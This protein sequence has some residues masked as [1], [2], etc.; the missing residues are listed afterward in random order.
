MA[1]LLDISSKLVANSTN[2]FIQNVSPNK[3][4]MKWISD[5]IR[6]NTKRHWKKIAVIGACGVLIAGTYKLHSDLVA[7]REQQDLTPGPEVELLSKL[8]NVQSV[9]LDRIQDVMEV[10]THRVD[11]DKEIEDILKISEP[12]CDAFM[13]DQVNVVK[14]KDETTESLNARLTNAYRKKN[15]LSR[16]KVDQNDY[17]IALKSL[18]NRAKLAF[19]IPKDS[20]LHVQAVNLFLYKECRKLNI[21]TADAARLIPQAVALSI[22]PNDEQIAY[23]QVLKLPEIQRRYLA[24]NWRGGSPSLGVRMVNSIRSWVNK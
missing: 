23:G 12:D 8:A 4:E 18:V 2:S 14:G 11:E 21:R 22:L 13:Q 17:P 16:K 15:R 19:P 6:V 20:D 3:T 7:W 10:I 24:R 5:L 1:F 9:S